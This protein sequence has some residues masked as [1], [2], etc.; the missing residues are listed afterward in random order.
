MLGNMKFI[1]RV[2]QLG[3]L[4]IT[5]FIFPSIHVLFSIYTNYGT[6]RNGTVTATFGSRRTLL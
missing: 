5:D 1:S 3:Y 6:V 2:E 4:K